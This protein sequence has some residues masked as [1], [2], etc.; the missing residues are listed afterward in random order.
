MG[1]IDQHKV[2]FPMVHNVVG[3][4]KDTTP[5][6]MPWS[7]DAFLEDQSPKIGQKSAIGS[8]ANT[9]Q[10]KTFFPLTP[11]L[12]GF[13]SKNFSPIMSSSRD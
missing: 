10:H 2:L 4:A 3:F 1:N 11:K 13:A 7:R 12:I 5:S 8:I 6:S 9:D